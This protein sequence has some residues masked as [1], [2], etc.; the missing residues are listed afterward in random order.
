MPVS[1]HGFDREAVTPGLFAVVGVVTAVYCLFEVWRA[2]AARPAPAVPPEA[3]LLGVTAVGH[4]Y[5]GYWLSTDAF[6]PETT[7]RVGAAAA[8]AAV[9]ATAAVVLAV[10]VTLGGLPSF[11]TAV[12]LLVAAGTEGALVGVVLAALWLP[13]V[14]VGRTG[15]TDAGTAVGDGGRAVAEPSTTDRERLVTLHS[16]VRHNVRNRVNVVDGRLDLLVEEAEGVDDRQRSAIESQLDAILELLSDVSVAVDAV[17]DD[18]SREPVPLRSVVAEQVAVLESTHDGLSVAV[19]VDPELSVLA[20]DLLPAV[21]ENVLS[22]AV[23]HHDRDTASVTVTAEPDGDRVHLRIA[24]DG[25]GI[26]DRLGDAVLEPEV[27]DGSGMG[28]YLVDTLVSGYGGSVRLSD[29]EPRGTVVEL[30]LP[31]AE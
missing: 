23:H 14:P 3:V 19:D 2:V 18:G 30:T 10:P 24:D 22:N 25:P 27:G 9:V 28:L 5:T 26:P 1:K 12:F 13:S 16:L 6:D 31:R 17:S 11:G 20:D 7:W 29:N 15:G 21:V 8:A 4:L